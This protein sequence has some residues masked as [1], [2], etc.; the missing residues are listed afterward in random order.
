MPPSPASP[1]AWRR[2]DFP[3][4]NLC[5]LV[6]RFVTPPGGLAIDLG[7]GNGRHAKYLAEH[8]FDAI[9]VESDPDMLAACAMTGVRT[10][11]GKLEEFQLPSPPRLVLAWGLMMLS[12]IDD[13]ERR[14]AALGGEWVIADWRT[15]GNTFL[16]GAETRSEGGGVRAVVVRRPGHHLDGLRYRVFD[17]SACEL[18]GYERVHLQR[19]RIEERGTPLAGTDGWEVHEWWQTAHRRH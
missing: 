17:E 2:F 10:F 1:S 6:Q 7:C 18:P 15:P 3:D 16:D 13:C 11:A 9:G 19:C 12:A 14:V 8:G 4:A 5:D